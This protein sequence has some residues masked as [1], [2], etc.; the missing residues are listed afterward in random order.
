MRL[1]QHDVGHVHRSVGIAAQREAPQHPLGIHQVGVLGYLACGTVSADY[2]I[3]A[4]IR[5][6]G[7]AHAIDAL[8]TS[9]DPADPAVHRIGA[10]GD[11]RLEEQRIEFLARDGEC[12]VGIVGA[13]QSG[14]QNFPPARADH[15]HV[16]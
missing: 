16:P 2:H 14:Q 8:V 13:G 10:C 5:A 9:K 7:Q 3:G 12:V 15:N 1:P 4:N 6:S 11:G